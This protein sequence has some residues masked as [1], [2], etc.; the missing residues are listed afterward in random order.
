MY[1]T[2]VILDEFGKLEKGERV[3]VGDVK[4]KDESWLRDILF[5]NPEII[6]T[7]DIDP[8]YGVLVPLCKELRTD[9]GPI[10]AVFINEHGRLTIVECKL[11]RNP[12]ARRE[13]VAQT[14]H[15]ASALS[16]WSYADLQRQVAA[17]VGKQGNIPFELVQKH[18]G[19]RLREQEFVDA[20]T[21]SLREGRFLIL[22]AGD[23][24]REG[25]QALTDLV[26]R[27]AT[28]AFSF[29]LI[30][31]AIYRFGKGRFAIQPRVIA[32]TEL[33]T[34]QI[35]VV[36]LKED[37]SARIIIEDEE[38]D[39]SEQPTGEGKEHLKKWWSPLFKMKFND[40]EQERPFWTGSNNLVLNTPF[41]GIQIKAASSVDKDNVQI[42]LSGTR[43]ENVEAIRRFVKRDKQ[44]LR[45]NLPEGTII[46]TRE[47]FPVECK[48]Q[49]PISDAEK[50]VWIGKT[51][52]AFVDV[53]RPRLRKWHEEIRV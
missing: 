29:G 22:I 23:G 40:P 4:G 38:A 46:N 19:G 45:D 26:N 44:Y 42:F 37:V 32:E 6:P 33:V 25:V 51:L 15:Y 48:N 11:W 5:D 8:A 9:A 27:N 16:G 28:K 21:R 43:W 49:S 31:V 17:A 12:E 3:F 24:I 41:P 39:G 36:N 10:D 1:G 52:N 18:A 35:T 14:L 50:H 34:R 2:V 13:V 47:G 20:V 53:L 7:D 30:E